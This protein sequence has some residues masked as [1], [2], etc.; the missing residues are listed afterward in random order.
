VNGVVAES[1][2]G[3]DLDGTATMTTRDETIATTDRQALWSWVADSVRPA[4]GWILLGLGALALFLGWYG[5]SGQ[6]LPAK[7]LPY[8]ISGG[9]TGLGLIVVGSVVLATAHLRRQLERLDGIERKMNDLY[10]LL[11]LEPP[12][13]SAGPS[14][15]AAGFTDAAVTAAAQPAGYLALPTGST[16]HRA[17]CPL[18]TGKA[19]AVGVDEAAIA[20]RALEPCP[21]CD[22][23]GAGEGG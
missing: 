7:Q 21:V 17:S 14:A 13:D 18:V 8:L 6:S 19:A 2:E 15:K 22:P 10:A 23:R 5:V 20:A 1:D 11:V 3:D 12:P 4:L 16:F 9:L